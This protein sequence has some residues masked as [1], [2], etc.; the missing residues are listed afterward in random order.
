VVERR[1]DAMKHARKRTAAKKRPTSNLPQPA[2]V[3]RAEEIPQS[4]RKR[5]G[6]E[7]PP[8]SGNRPAP[9]HQDRSEEKFHG[10]RACEALFARRPGD[11]VRVYLVEERKRQFAALLDSCV[12]ERKGF[13]VVGPEN[14]ERLTGSIHHEGIAILARQNPPLDVCRSARGDRPRRSAG[15]DPAPRWPAEPA[16]SRLDSP[17]RGPLRR[18]RDHRGRGLAAAAL[19]RRGAGCGGRRRGRARL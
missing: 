1:L 4:S 2:T 15:P 18:R 16:Q 17:H 13:Q 14:L 10:L 11:I 19:T 9:R 5:P 6:A 12:R 7:R 3:R 8:R